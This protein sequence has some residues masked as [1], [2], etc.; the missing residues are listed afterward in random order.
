MRRLQRSLVPVLFSALVLVFSAPFGSAD[1][2]VDA[3]PPGEPVEASEDSPGDVHAW[4]QAAV[5]RLAIELERLFG[6]LYEK[7][8]HAPPQTTALQQRSR[9]AAQGSI[10]RARDRSAEYAQ[11]MRAGWDRGASEPYF[12]LVVEEVTDIFDTAGNAEPVES[13]Q[14]RIDRMQYV[15]SELQAYYDGT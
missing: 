2:S 9:E 15:I 4:D 13:A 5:T 14:P 7:S 6:E 11:K 1:D 10:R 8:Q 12:R 3:K